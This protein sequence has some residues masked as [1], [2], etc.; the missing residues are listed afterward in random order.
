MIERIENARFIA[1]VSTL[2]A[3]LTRI[4]RKDNDTE[5][6][7]NGDETYWK[8]HAPVLFP[9]VGRLHEGTYEYDGKVYGI[10]LHGF[11]QQ[12]EFAVV[13]NAGDSVTLS[14]GPD[15]ERRAMY[16]FDFT[17]SVTYRLTDKG[18]DEIAEVTN[19]GSSEM[20]YGFGGH[21]GFNVPLDKGLSFEDYEVVFPEAGQIMRRRFT[22]NH[23][24][25]GVYDETDTVKDGVMSLHHD[26]FDDDATHVANLKQA[27]GKVVGRDK[28]AIRSLSAL[29]DGLQE[30]LTYL[31]VLESRRAEGTFVTSGFQESMVDP[32]V[33]G[34]I[35][36]QGAGDFQ[37]LMELRELM[38]SGMMRLA[39]QKR[40]EAG[41]RLMEEK[42]NTM[43]AVAKKRDVKALFQADNEFHDAVSQLC[44][45]PIADKINRVVRTLTHAVR[46]RTVET[47]VSTGRAADLVEAHR[48]LYEMLRDRNLDRLD[49]KINDTYFLDVGLGAADKAEP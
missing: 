35:L 3:Q 15:D 23:L 10:T 7:W 38:E 17:F 11:C 5:Y 33:Y 48:T 46:Y 42:L 8:K 22:D 21:P 14:I 6:L 37:N 39:I 2:G 16:P 34:V 31:G 30:I 4:Y 13:S 32:M 19:N 36:N 47:M 44:Q 49:E 41:L 1:E 29:G 9:F 45:N 12:A 26:L 28:N 20:L 40:D 27:E 24:D 18:V 25:A 43:S